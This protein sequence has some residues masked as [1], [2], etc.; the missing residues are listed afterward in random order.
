VN[1]T[2]VNF[3]FAFAED[4]VIIKKPVVWHLRPN[5]H[6]VAIFEFKDTVADKKGTSSFCNLDKFK[7]RVVVPYVMIL[8]RLIMSYQDCL[9]AIRKM[10]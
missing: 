2:N 8:W 6:A 1:D 7:F 10:M 3:S 9:L 4:M 5:E